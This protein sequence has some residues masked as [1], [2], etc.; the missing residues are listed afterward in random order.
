MLS[1]HETRLTPHVWYEPRVLPR[2][3]WICG[4]CGRSVAS[5]RGYTSASPSHSGDAPTGNVTRLYVCPNC[6]GP[7]LFTL[8]GHQFPGAR[9]GNAV[10]NVPRDVLQLYD[11]AREC[12][13]VGA[14]TGAVMLC[15][16]IL[17][18]IAVERGAKENQRFVQ[19]VEYLKENNF[20]PPGG[21]GWVS[22]I[23][24][25]GN[26]ANHEIKAMEKSEALNLIRFAEML[27]RFVY[28]FPSLVPSAP[29]PGSPSAS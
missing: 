5:D 16:K 20:I 29:Q 13:I 19:Y 14:Y 1:E 22:Y 10:T 11:E 26:E 3:A 12:C 28:E 24:D 17:M 21:E 6:D 4:F 2:R 23:K 25:R 18:H 9:P 7:T 8:S 27:L 15:R